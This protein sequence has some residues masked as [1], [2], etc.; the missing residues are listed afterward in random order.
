[1]YTALFWEFVARV[2]GCFEIYFIGLALDINIDFIDA[3]IIS[4]GSSLFANLVFFFPMQLGT[5][6]GGLAMA[7]MS[8]GLPAKVGIFMGV[9]TR[10]R[11]IVWIM[12]GLGWMSLVK[13]K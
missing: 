1:F 2:V 12:I 4:S 8:I 9:V 7:V 13:K 10:I 11:E 3:M 6:E 5:R